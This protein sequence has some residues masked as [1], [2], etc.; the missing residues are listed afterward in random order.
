MKLIESDRARQ[1]LETSQF[2]R[3][4]QHYY[5]LI[6]GMDYSIGQILEL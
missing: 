3:W 2:N 5:R 6:A 4:Y 1:W